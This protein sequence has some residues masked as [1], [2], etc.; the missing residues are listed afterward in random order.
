MPFCVLRRIIMGKHVSMRFLRNGKLLF[1]LDVGKTLDLMNSC[2]RQR[3]AYMLCVASS[4]FSFCAVLAES[5][6][7]SV[8]F[9]LPKSIWKGRCRKEFADTRWNWVFL[10]PPFQSVWTAVL[11]IPFIAF[12]LRDIQYIFQFL[13]NASCTETRISSVVDFFF[14]ADSQK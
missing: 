8:M 13:R 14:S 10:S 7:S 9:T 11:I 12:L 5:G 1:F 4:R 6:H 3:F 2:P